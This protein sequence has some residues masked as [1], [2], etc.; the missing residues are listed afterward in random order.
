MKAMSDDGS[1]PPQTRLE[2]N[3]QRRTSR[4]SDAT[5]GALL[6]GKVLAAALAL[7]VV[8]GTGY[9]S[10]TYKNFISN[11]TTLGPGV[12]S[13]TLT[14]SATG[15]GKAK[16]N[17]KTAG[18]DENILLVGDD[19]RTGATPA[20]LKLLNTQDDGGGVNTDTMMVLHVPA[21]GSKA[22][23]ISFPRDTY[24][25][26]PGIG[27]TKLNAVYEN[28][29]QNG[30]GPS[31]GA[32]ALI[33]VLQNLTGLHIDHYVAVT[34]LG[35][36][37]IAQA[38]GPI[39]VCMNA[40]VSDA[41]SETY[42]PAGVSTLNASQALSFVRQR[43]G[44]PRG[45]LDRE[46]RQQYFL[47]TEFRK[48]TSAGTLLN[49]LKLES[50]LKAVSSSLTVDSGLDGTGLLKFASQIQD[51]SA[52]N[53]TFATIPIVG[54]PTITVN[55]SPLSI[56]EIDPVKVK[57]FVQSTIGVPS[58]STAYDKA[59][60]AAP[61][62]VTVQVVN[63]GSASGSATT[64]TAKLAALGFKATVGQDASS[65]SVVTTITY[66]T[67]MEAQAKAVAKLVPGAQVSAVASGSAVIL[68]LG[69]DGMTVSAPSTAAA[70]STAGAAT[71][72]SA[73]ATSSSSTAS[74]AP[75]SFSAG[76][77]IN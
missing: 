76:E 3:R 40:T 26:A 50:L 13:P 58:T 70:T 75:R 74:G 41:Y 68:S 23:G 64:T 42:L 36:Y 1:T 18:V 17:P 8:V 43:H 57:A 53:V 60:A 62:S 39:Q 71:T 67:G 21:N 66:P 54:T 32:A 72:P 52:G 63:A 7:A 29:T 6:G 65:S 51:L 34:L 73:P 49:P 20:E 10:L 12:I 5:R 47:A 28:G 11:I 22:T 48:L 30:K 77:C 33:N 69:Q 35:F 9:L 61:A 16:A 15:T 25:D 19:D 55:G 37:R 27:M 14:P 44:L 59:I 2:R 24:L 38:L 46:V 56:V 31:G 4:R 45:D